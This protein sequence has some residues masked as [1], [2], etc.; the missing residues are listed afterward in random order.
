MTATTHDKPHTT[1]VLL[2]LVM[3]VIRHFQRQGRE[4]QLQCYFTWTECQS[5][6]ERCCPRYS[7]T[8]SRSYSYTVFNARSVLGAVASL[9]S[10][11][12]STITHDTA[13]SPCGEV[14]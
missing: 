12:G 6:G 2:L 5:S 4:L 14:S 13:A 9:V 3:L 10:S 7:I 8:S 11:P 1:K